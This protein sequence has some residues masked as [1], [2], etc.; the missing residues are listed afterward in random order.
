MRAP[1]K[2]SAKEWVFAAAV[3]TVVR[4][5]ALQA[6]EVF[7]YQGDSKMYALLG[8]NLFEHRVLSLSTEAPY[9]PAAIRPPLVPVLYAVSL[10]VSPTSPLKVVAAIQTLLSVFTALLAAHVFGR[11]LSH[12][13]R[14]LL[15]AFVLVPFDA[16]YSGEIWSDALSGYFL[17]MMLCALLSTNRARWWLAGLLGGALALV[18]DIYLPLPLLFAAVCLWHC[19]FGLSFKRRWAQFPA[20]VLGFALVVAPWTL[21]NAIQFG[22]LIPVSKGL[23][24]FGLWVGTWER[25]GDWMKRAPG[26]EYDYPSYAFQSERERQLVEDLRQG[27]IQKHTEFVETDQPFLALAK[28]RIRAQPLAVLATYFKRHWHLWVGSRNDQFLLN[29]AFLKTGTVTWKLFKSA[30]WGL[31]IV[32]CTVGL[33]GLLFADSRR[34]KALA[35]VCLVPIAATSL[36]YFPFHNIETR[37]SQPVLPLLL[38]GSVMMLSQL[39]ASRALRQR[40]HSVRLRWNR[41]SVV[42][43]P[44]TRSLP[45]PL[46]L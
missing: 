21:R 18:R 15:W 9:V 43:E 29:Q 24:G 38:C 1:L 30:S 36:V 7:D 26:G 31:S 34:R 6:V 40:L 42:V 19:F 33:S 35:R 39:F 25:N 16:M 14:A 3:A 12:S 10:W 32:L 5:L 28:E 4:L 2:I 44:A 17:L 45:K 41:P 11:W 46:E 8:R 23:M 37:Y 22:S 27:K 20:F 13:K